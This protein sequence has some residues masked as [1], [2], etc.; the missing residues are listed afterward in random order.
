VNKPAGGWVESVVTF[1]THRF[2]FLAAMYNP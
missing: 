2:V 1:D